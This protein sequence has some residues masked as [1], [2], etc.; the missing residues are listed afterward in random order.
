MPCV[1]F[2]VHV[3]VCRGPG[4]DTLIFSRS[5][6]S[7]L[8]TGNA[9]SLCGATFSC[10]PRP[11]SHSHSHYGFHRRRKGPNSSRSL[12]WAFHHLPTTSKCQITFPHNSSRR[13]T[14]KKLNLYFLTPTAPA[15]QAGAPGS[16]LIVIN[17]PLS[18]TQ[19]YISNGLRI[20]IIT[21]P[22]V[23]GMRDKNQS[24]TRM[25]IS[26]FRAHCPTTVGNNSVH[27]HIHI[28]R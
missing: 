2:C 15:Q 10:Q 1:S 11:S 24:D 16:R 12:T 7:S 25:Y 23:K 13:R 19:P 4:Q 14:E 21:I 5:I 6:F 18:H 3:H 8:G 20:P 26:S 28:W 27:I 17:T 9:V 22:K